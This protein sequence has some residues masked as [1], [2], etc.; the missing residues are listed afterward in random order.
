MAYEHFYQFY[1]SLMDDVPYSKYT[2]LVKQYAKQNDYI[3]DIGCGT[4]CIL[5]SLIENGFLVDGI[6]I[7]D[8]M[9]LVTKQKLMEKNLNANLF[10]DDMRNIMIEDE[11]DLIISFLDT[12]NYLYTLEDVSLTFKK[13]YKALKNEGYF[14][15]DIHSLYKLHHVLDGYSYNETRNDFTYLWN[16][17][18]EREAS[19]STVHHE[20]SFF[21]EQK[22]N[23]YKRLDEFHQQ[24]VFPLKTYIQILEDIGFEIEKTQ[25]DFDDSKNE[26]NCDKM[27]VV[28]KKCLT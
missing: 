1:D 14:I 11:Y 25:Y 24:V 8:E 27:I 20:L 9:L 16:S 3:L 10:Q 23:L 22:N 26:S 21:I 12:I 28:A 7:S 19:Y 2:Q 6:D 13:I 17:Y 15:F 4:G 18:V 5:I